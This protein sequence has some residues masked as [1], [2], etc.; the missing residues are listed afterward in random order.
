MTE[1]SEVVNLGQLEAKYQEKK[2]IYLVAQ[3]LVNVQ[4]VL[5]N[6]GNVKED[7]LRRE[8]ADLEMKYA[9]VCLVVE[10]IELFTGESY[11]PFNVIKKFKNEQ[12]F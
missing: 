2:E 6:Q 5:Y 10:Q 4:R 1:E 9:D 3:I 12:I 7:T 11:S 8:V